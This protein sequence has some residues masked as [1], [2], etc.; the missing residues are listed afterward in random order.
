M[1]PVANA[2]LL[3]ALVTMIYATLGVNFFGGKVCSTAADRRT[4]DDAGVGSVCDDEMNPY[5]AKFSISLLSMFQVCTGDAWVGF[6]S[7]SIRSSPHFPSPSF[8]V[9]PTT[10]HRV[11]QAKPRMLSLRGLAWYKWD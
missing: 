7:V 11:Y 9:F 3:L 4:G 8:L 2:I 6:L 10:L 5:F 1:V